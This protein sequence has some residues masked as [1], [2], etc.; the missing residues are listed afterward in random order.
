MRYT[1]AD[2]IQKQ[3]INQKIS[4]R[5]M[6]HIVTGLVREVSGQKTRNEK[7]KQV[8]RGPRHSGGSE[9]G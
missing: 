8:T 6:G 9:D 5:C 2:K 4:E 1:S 3:N 7:K